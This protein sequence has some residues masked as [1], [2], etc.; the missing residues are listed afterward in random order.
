MR[1][2]S[3]SNLPTLSRSEI[4]RN[5]TNHPLS[6]S[7]T[8]PGHFKSKSSNDIPFQ[9]GAPSSSYRPSSGRSTPSNGQSFL[10][11]GSPG[12]SAHRRSYSRGGSPYDP[13][14]VRAPD[15][16]PTEPTGP[17]Y[18][19]GYSYP[20]SASTSSMRDNAMQDAALSTSASKYECSYCGK[21]FNRP[22]SLKVI[23]NI[24]SLPGLAAK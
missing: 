1:P 22:S 16:E 15:A 3:S 14:P 7:Y 9:Q 24:C 8:S 11:V 23:L 17:P 4:D 13:R 2:R 5:F 19:E 21:G 18:F 6:R 12:M 20:P 10:P